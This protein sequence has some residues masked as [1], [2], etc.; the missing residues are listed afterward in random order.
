MLAQRPTCGASKKRP[1]ISALPSA[2]PTRS[3]DIDAT[4]QIDAVFLTPYPRVVG[5]NTHGR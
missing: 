2:D 1:P 3:T 5:P 4:A